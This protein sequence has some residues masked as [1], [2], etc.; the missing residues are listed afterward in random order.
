M[1]E[2]DISVEKTLRTDIYN[3]HLGKVAL[4][5]LKGTDNKVAELSAHVDSRLDIYPTGQPRANISLE[6]AHELAK[7]GLAA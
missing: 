4:I 2:F 3:N 5:G 6:R 1:S 7:I